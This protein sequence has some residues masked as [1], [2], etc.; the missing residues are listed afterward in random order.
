[1]QLDR[2][3]ERV[4]RRR[5]GNARRRAGR[6]AAPYG[7]PRGARPSRCRP[8]SAP[9]S[10]SRSRCRPA[11][12]P[13]CSGGGGPGT[14]LF[15]PGAQGRDVADGDPVWENS[16]RPRRPSFPGFTASAARGSARSRREVER[17]L[18]D[19]G[20]GAGSTPVGIGFPRCFLGR[21]AP[22][23]DA[24]LRRECPGVELRSVGTRPCGRTADAAVQEAVGSPLHAIVVRSPGS[25]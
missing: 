24:H 14:G 20:V 3:L 13:V 8:G 11:E 6:V 25:A 2:L 15:V 23:G 19:L 7:S 16:S 5:A 22:C 4:A 17:L 10:C 1:V 9:M 21:L 18:G 12:L